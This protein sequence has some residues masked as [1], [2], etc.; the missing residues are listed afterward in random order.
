M[1]E[2]HNMWKLAEHPFLGQGQ[3]RTGKRLVRSCIKVT[4]SCPT[5]STLR[6]AAYQ[7]PVSVGYSR[8]D[9]WSGLPCPPQLCPDK[10]ICDIME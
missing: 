9:Y 3:G 2:L 5:L 7:D 6:T 4:Q 10:I 8:Q 1:T